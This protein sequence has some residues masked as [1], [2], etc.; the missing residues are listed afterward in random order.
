LITG[1]GR[2]SAGY[3]GVRVERVMLQTLPYTWAVA[4]GGLVLTAVRFL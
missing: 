4:V 1:R 2:G 3:A